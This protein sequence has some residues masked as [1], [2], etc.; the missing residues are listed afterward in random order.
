MDLDLDLGVQLTCPAAPGDDFA[1]AATETDAAFL[2][3]PKDDV[4]VRVCEAGAEVAVRVASKE[5]F[6]VEASAAGR[7]RVAHRQV[8]EGF[9]RVF[10]VPA[11]VDVARITVGFEE[12]D[13][14]LVVI[15]PKLQPPSDGGGDEEEARMEVESAECDDCESLV[16]G[17]EV[18]VESEPEPGDV[19]VEVE[20]EVVDDEASS[21][22]ME[23]ED[24]VD[25][26]SEPESEPRRDVPVETQVEVV[27]EREV[28]VETPVEVVEEREVPVETPVL[29][30]EDDA[31]G[32][33]RV[34]RRVRPAV[35][36]AAAGGGDADRGG[37]A[38]V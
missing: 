23:H 30:E 31:G 20:M 2:G 9:R 16:S 14:L 36:G 1:F 12:D 22:E 26:K 15:M 38:A 28:P 10:D 35:P 19:P 11:G 18:E 34:R 27:E 5:A 13:G 7:V 29:V 33:H 32:R 25:V 24:W 3:T 6:A 4:D 21:I 8:V 37:G 17:E